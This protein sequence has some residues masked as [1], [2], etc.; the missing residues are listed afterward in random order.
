LGAFSPVAGAPATG[1]NR[2]FRSNSSPP[3]GVCGII[4]PA[5]SAPDGKTVQRTVL[6]FNRLRGLKASFA[7]KVDADFRFETGIAAVCSSISMLCEQALILCRNPER[8][9]RFTL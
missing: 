1:E 8:S 5:I 4:R 3:C 7:V 2:A 9:T 6:C